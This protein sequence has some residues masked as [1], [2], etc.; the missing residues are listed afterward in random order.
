MI[1]C[2]KIMYWVRKV[3]NYILNL[4]LWIQNAHIDLALHV[5]EHSSCSWFQHWHTALPYDNGLFLSKHVEI[6]S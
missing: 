6:M 4:I 5:M 1:L 3:F 2:S